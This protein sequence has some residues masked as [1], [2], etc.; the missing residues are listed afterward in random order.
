MAEEQAGVVLFSKALIAGSSAI[1]IS[2]GGVV[3]GVCSSVL[4]EFLTPCG[5]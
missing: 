2:R 3:W 1:V 4:R 5:F